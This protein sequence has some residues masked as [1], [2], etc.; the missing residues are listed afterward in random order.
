VEEKREGKLVSPVA[1]DSIRQGANSL[2][3]RPDSTRN[4]LLQQY[5]LSYCDFEMQEFGS[6][7]TRNQILLDLFQ[8]NPWLKEYYGSIAS[9]LNFRSMIAFAEIGQLES[10][11]K[12]LTEL[13][14]ANGNGNGPLFFRYLFGL[15]VGA[16]YFEDESLLTECES[17]L[18]PNLSHYR[19]QFNEVD[20]L[21]LLIYCT[22]LKIRHSHFRGL[23][24]ILWEINCYPPSKLKK[25]VRFYSKVYEIIEA[26]GDKEFAGMDEKATSL[27]R[28]AS[29]HDLKDHLPQGM[30]FVRFFNQYLKCGD[31]KAVRLLL[32]ESLSMLEHSKSMAFQKEKLYFDFEQFLRLMAKASNIIL[33]QNSA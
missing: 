26:W 24:S 20:Y 27:T 33:D 1:L 31:A 17:F 5:I 32:E 11:Q 7:S 16:D 2:I 22:K 6:A 13:K 4:F 18:L 9:V 15:L 12:H 25:E 29:K 14:P 30:A 10:F 28:F 3:V 23:K 8:E 21:N 19:S